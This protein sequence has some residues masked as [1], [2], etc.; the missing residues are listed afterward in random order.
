MEQMKAKEKEMKDEKEDLRQ[1]GVPSHDGPDATRPLT[2]YAA[3]GQGSPREKSQEGRKGEIREDGRENA[4]KAS[5]AVEA[6]GEA[7]QAAEFLSGRAALERG[8]LNLGTK[9][10]LREAFRN[11]WLLEGLAPTK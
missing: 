6:E 11:P 1:V 5:R 9:L 4:P 8:A 3:T 10:P 2:H 7:E